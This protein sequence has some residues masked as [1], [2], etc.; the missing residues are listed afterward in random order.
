MAVKHFIVHWG[1]VLWLSC[2]A[3]L[4]WAQDEIDALWQEDTAAS[5]RPAVETVPPPP[6]MVAAL[7]EEGDG[8]RIG[9]R[10]LLEIDVF[11]VPELTRKV[12]VDARGRIALPLVGSL[13][14]EGKTPEELG[15]A[16]A[17]RLAQRYVNDP[18]VT[19]FVVEY[20][21]Q[22]VT[23]EGAVN[24]PG[25]FPL[26]GRTSLLQ[27]IA[28]A[29]GLTDLA[30]ADGVQLFRTLADGRKVSYLFDVAAI[31]KGEAPDPLVQADDVIVVP[32]S[33]PKSLLRSV[34]NTLRGFISFGTYRP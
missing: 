31:R 1:A 25:I 19:V 4:S 24:R 9:V 33:G 29:E 22:R 20:E 8:Y 16:I 26:K 32:R 6:P 27:V 10:D 7:G 15:A 18:Y 30:D 34:T 21:S 28:Q 12:R 11:R 14:A 13:P 5:P 23:V 17:E 3:A 2:S